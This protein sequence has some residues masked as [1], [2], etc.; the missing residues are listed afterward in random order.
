MGLL[1]ERMLEQTLCIAMKARSQRDGR[2]TAQRADMFGIFTQNLTEN[3]LGFLAVFAR[4]ALGGL[5]E[6]RS[7]GVGVD[8]PLKCVP[9]TGKIAEIC[10]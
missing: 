5:G 4:Q 7:I 2:Q 8:E 10:Q 3:R 9:G 6:N 1:L